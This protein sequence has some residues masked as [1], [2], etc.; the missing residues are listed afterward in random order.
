M[1]M[2]LDIYDALVGRSSVLQS[3]GHHCVIVRPLWHSK[4]LCFPSSGYILIQLYLENPSMKDIVSNHPHVLS[5]M[6]SMNGREN[7]YLGQATF[8]SRKSMHIWVL[9]LFFGYGENVCHPVGM[10]FLPDEARVY[11]HLHFGF[12]CVHQF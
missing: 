8:K 10:L 9:Q 4:S 2:K 11:K 1:V 12:Y 5:K 6:M 7:S 3:E